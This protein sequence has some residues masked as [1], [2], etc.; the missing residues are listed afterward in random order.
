MR[1]SSRRIGRM[2]KGVRRIRVKLIN[3]RRADESIQRLVVDWT[4]LGLIGLREVE[5]EVRF[6]LEQSCARIDTRQKSWT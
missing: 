5:V 3:I 4:Q 2:L 6:K 1:L